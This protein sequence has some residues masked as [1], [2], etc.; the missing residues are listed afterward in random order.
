MCGIA[1]F[2]RGGR[3]G[4]LDV[5]TSLGLSMAKAIAYRGPD[6]EG[7]WTDDAARMT[8]AHRRLSI[9]DLSPAGAQPMHSESGRYVIAYNGEIYNYNDLKQALEVIDPA[10]NWRGHS[11]TEVLLASIEQWGLEATLQR[12]IGMFAIA[13]WDRKEQI[14]T[15]ARDRFGEK[16]L[17]YGWQGNGE[18]RALLF[19]SEPAAMLQ[20]PA[21]EKR[22][23]RRAVSE[24]LRYNY[25]PAPLS[26][27]EGIAKLSPGT[28]A[29]FQ[30][31]EEEPKIIAYWDMA[32][33]ANAGISSRFQGSIEEAVGETER[34]L[35][36]SVARQ[37]V[38]DVPLGAFLSG[39]I[40]SSTIVALMQHQSARAVKTFTI[41]FEQDGYNEAVHAAAVAKHLQTEH[42]ELYVSPS[43]TLA[44]IPKLP[45]IYSEPFADSSQVPTFLV[46]EMTQQYVTV[47][48]SGDAGDEIFGGYNRYLMTQRLWGLL[49]KL[50]VS[51]RKLAAR[52]LTVPSPQS[53]NRIGGRFAQNRWAMFGDKIHK[54]AALLPLQSVDALYEKFITLPRM[55]NIMKVREA[56]LVRKYDLQD[57]Q[58]VERMMALDSMQYL[59]DDILVKVDRA[60][61]AV[62]L[63]TR[64]PMLDKELVSFAWTLPHDYKVHQGKSK[65]PLR[66]ILYRYVPQEIVDRPKMGFG[67][68][69]GE[70]LRGPLRDWADDLLAHDKLQK[71]DLLDV[72]AVHTLWQEHLSGNRN[73]APQLW[74]ILMLQAW[75]RHNYG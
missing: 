9:L 43:D 71:D 65:W 61:M 62:S 51:M 56:P 37:M 53:W 47:A 25:I 40:D 26:I 24:Y 75:L 31:G 33:V 49:A 6:A 54:G 74:T 72:E 45:E 69:I 7:C 8:L 60:A 29:V 30:A 55:D 68:P 5:D 16:P 21:F 57:M 10:R 11:D 18:N 67:I 1:G 50:P 44:I 3:S 48:L 64:V 4:N 36:Q 63:E 12:A 35:K 46:S 23:N 14:F 66:Q 2:Y 19:A 13:L 70:W 52:A 20:H 22:I 59:P 58:D 38:A 27:Y 28:I 34:L 42:H 73:W 15:L 39:G 41:G 32:S 17:Y